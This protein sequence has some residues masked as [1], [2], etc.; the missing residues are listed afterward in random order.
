[1]WQQTRNRRRNKKIIISNGFD[2]L[3]LSILFVLWIAG[4]YFNDFFFFCFIFLSLLCVYVL[5]CVVGAFDFILGTQVMLPLI[6]GFVIQ[7]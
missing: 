1:M 5:W 6:S 2:T 4:G 7:S 3:L